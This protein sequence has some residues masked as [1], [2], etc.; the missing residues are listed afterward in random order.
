[1]KYVN[2]MSPGFVHTKY[3]IYSVKI[4]NFLTVILK[5]SGLDELLTSAGIL[6]QI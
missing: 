2:G 6:F 3:L 4:S 5:D 1:M